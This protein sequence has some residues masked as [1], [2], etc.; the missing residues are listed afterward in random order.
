MNIVWF[1]RD[2]RLSDHA[3][4]KAALQ[5][6]S[7]LLMLYIWEPSVMADPH[8]DPRH[9][10]FVQQSLL[11]LNEQFRAA[12]SLVSINILEGEAVDIFA[13]IHQKYGINNVFSYQETG[14]QVTYDRDKALAKWFKN[15]GIGWTEFQTDRKSTRLNSS[16]ITPSRMPSS[17]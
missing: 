15:Q 11:D 2:L 9:W 4:L 12:D 7:P 10:R 16:H 8:Y 14:L 3:P 6:S 17:A 1:K 13:F 5:D